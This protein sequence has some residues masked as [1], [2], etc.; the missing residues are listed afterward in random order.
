MKRTCPDCGK[1]FEISGKVLV[2]LKESFKR[3]PEL[4]LICTTCGMKLDLKLYLE[5]MKKSSGK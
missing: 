4:K 3:N 1:E 5:R 2:M